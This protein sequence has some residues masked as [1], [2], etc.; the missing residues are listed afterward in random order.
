MGS[1]ARN[2]LLIVWAALTTI[3]LLSWGI[4]SSHGS[5]TIRPDAAVAL[6]AI[7]ITLIKVRVI[8]REFMD[9]RSAPKKLKTVTDAWL[10]TFG[11]AMLAAYFL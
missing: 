5:G 7:A 2:R 11:L 4:G 3:T 6:G 9:V 1:T 8:V 10:I